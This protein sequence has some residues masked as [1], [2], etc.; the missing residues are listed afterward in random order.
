M[1]F[2]HSPFLSILET[3]DGSQT[4]RNS[5]IG[6]TYHSMHGAHT[7]SQHVFVAKGLEKAFEYGVTD[8]TIL[9]MG[10]GT[11]LN[12]I[13][14]LHRSEQLK[15]NVNYHALELFP[16]P[17]AIWSNYSL[18]AELN[19]LNHHFTTIHLAPWN[20]EIALRGSF[21]FAKHQ[22]SLL[23]YDSEPLFDLVF[24]D[25]FDPEVQPELWTVAVFEKLSAMMNPGAI[26]TT[27]SC[28][29]Q[30]RRNMLA[31]GLEVEKIPGPPGKREML[32]A[33]KPL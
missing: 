22:I 24:F 4:I 26:L 13:L 9:E 16:L 23:D 25:A 31:S 18:P 10:L 8:V 14:T 30:V 29:G 17:E 3:S 33:F 12:A 27:Y 5:Q 1:S 7:E 28:K 11:G 15:V 32:R 19:H 20:E 6:S 21:K 2:K